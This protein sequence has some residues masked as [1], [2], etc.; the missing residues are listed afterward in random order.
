MSLGQYYKRGRE[1]KITPYQIKKIQPLIE[2]LRKIERSVIPSWAEKDNPERCTYCGYPLH[3]K[4]LE[5]ICSECYKM[6]FGDMV[7]GEGEE[8]RLQEK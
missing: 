6:K 7:E 2:N 3:D 1:P 8:L 5:N 4:D